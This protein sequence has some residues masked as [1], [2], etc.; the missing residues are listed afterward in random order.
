MGVKPKQ[1]VKNIVQKSLSYSYETLGQFQ[2]ILESSGYESYIEGDN[3]NIKKGGTVLENILI[4]EIERHTQKRSKEQTQKR[5]MQ[6]K[7][8]LLKYRNITS[9]KEELNAVLKKKFGV[10]LVFMGKKDTPYG[11]IIVDHKEKASYKGKDVLGIKDLLRFKKEVVT[12]EN[13]DEI[14]I[15]IH[16][17]LEE[18]K[19]RTIGELNEKLWRKYKVN[20]FI[21]Y[22]G[23]TSR[24]KSCRSNVAEL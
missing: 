10:S 20:S 12:E 5:R 15:F 19:R 6:L 22:F 7:A 13:K 23:S 16:N 21:V 2:A 1:D 17:L 24:G 4:A 18:N 3:L 14:A 11:Y 8:I 9:N